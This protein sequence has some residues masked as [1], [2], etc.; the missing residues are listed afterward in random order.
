MALSRE[1]LDT[2]MSVACEKCGEPITHQGRWFASVWQLRC[3]VCGTVTAWGY[4][5]KLELFGIYAKQG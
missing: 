4:N 3:P 5:R 1:L 2:E